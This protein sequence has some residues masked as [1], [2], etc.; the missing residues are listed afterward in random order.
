LDVRLV[1]PDWIFSW[2]DL[3]VTAVSALISGFVIALIEETFFRGAL[4]TAVNRYSGLWPAAVLPSL[5]Y[6]A[7]HFIKTSYDISPDAVQWHSELIVLAHCFEQFADPAAILNSYLALF[8]VGVFLALARANT[9]GIA[10]CVGLHAGWVLIIRLAKDIT[11][12]DKGAELAFLVGDYD[13]ITGYLALVLITAVAVIYYCFA[14]QGRC[15]SRR[16]YRTACV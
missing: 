6:A 1:K 10:A 8:A 2:S 13:K 3:F 15:G 5:L 7:V 12:T 4:F 14:M 11:Q 16:H 9:G